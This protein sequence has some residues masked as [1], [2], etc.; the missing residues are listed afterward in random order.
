[1]SVCSRTP[2]REMGF[3]FFLAAISHNVIFDPFKCK[4][5]KKAASDYL[6]TICQEYG[7]MHGQMYTFAQ[8]E[9]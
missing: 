6:Q 3:F 8:A 7:C 5:T 1:M 9:I 4:Q 2:G